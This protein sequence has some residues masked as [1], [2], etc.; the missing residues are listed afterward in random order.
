MFFHDRS[1]VLAVHAERY[2]VASHASFQ[3]ARAAPSQ[4]NRVRRAVGRSLLVAGSRL[5]AEPPRRPA[6][7]P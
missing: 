4:P 1:V 6:R 5:V 3:P 2:A 7:T